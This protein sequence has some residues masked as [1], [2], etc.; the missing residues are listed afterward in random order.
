MAEANWTSVSE[1]VLLGLSE[2]QDMQPLIIAV[3]LGTYL[4]N[5]AGN[6]MLVGLVWTDPQLRSPMY[7]LL[8]QLSMVDMGMVS[9]ILP[10]AL[11]HTLSQHWAIPF[12]SCMAQLFILL[13][14]GNMENYLLAAMAYDRYVAVCN[15]LR[16]AAM[17]T[18]SL[19]LK[20]AAAF[21]VVVISHALL[22]TVMTARLRYC[23]NRLQHFFCHLEGYLL[24]AM[25]YDRYLAVCDP[26]RYATVVT[27]SLCLKMAAA[28]LAVVIPHGLLHTIMAAQLRYCGN[29][30]Q[31]FLCH[32]QSLMSLSCTRPVT[33]ELVVSTEGV[34]VVGAPFAFI[35][36]SYTRIGVAVARLRSVQALRKA[37]S[38]CGSHLTVVFLTYS[39]MLWLYFHPD[40]IKI[41]GHDQQVTFLYTAVVPTL[42]PLIY[43]LR[44]KDVAAA[45]RRAKRK[46]LC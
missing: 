29:R 43:S 7:F 35:L 20:M 5:L 21:W 15:P 45:L 26:L 10:Q 33:K 8:S 46:V 42:N 41:Q 23:G 14:V 1:F 16:Y 24:A 4:V 3:L 18:R 11:V 38:T 39:L 31:H 22:H 28:S 6:S 13:A 36:A 2:R 25:A 27:L 17:V 32:M 30:L 37:L 44:N 19:C 9:I 40:S 34:L 12:T